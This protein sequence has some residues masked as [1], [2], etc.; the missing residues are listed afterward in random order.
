MPRRTVLL[1]ISVVPNVKPRKEW[2]QRIWNQNF[3]R[4]WNNW[5]NLILFSIR[6]WH[7]TFNLNIFNRIPLFRWAGI[8]NDFD[9]YFHILFRL[10]YANQDHLRVFK[11][12]NQPPMQLNL[13][14]H[15]FRDEWS[16]LLQRMTISIPFTVVIHFRLVELREV[17]KKRRVIAFAI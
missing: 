8:S 1:C 11:S 12:I 5:K 15:C 17:K 16:P 9:L 7:D 3:E 14:L 2:I 13:M 10:N 4:T 6:H